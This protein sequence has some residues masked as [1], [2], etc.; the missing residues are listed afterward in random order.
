MWILS[1]VWMPL[2]Q[3]IDIKLFIN[4]AEAKWAGICPL[5]LS[6]AGKQ[7]DVNA[8]CKQQDP[9]NVQITFNVQNSNSQSCA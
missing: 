2:T 1:A 9:K 4:L 8:V 3:G 7:F 5:W 6:K